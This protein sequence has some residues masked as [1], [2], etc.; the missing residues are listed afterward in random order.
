[1]SSRRKSPKFSFCLE[2]GCEE[3]G[4]NSPAKR[5]RLGSDRGFGK[6][7]NEKV[8]EAGDSSRLRKKARSDVV[9]QSLTSSG[10]VPVGEEN[11]RVPAQA[12]D[13]QFGSQ[14]SISIRESP[15]T[16][17]YLESNCKLSLG[18]GCV[19]VL[20]EVEVFKKIEDGK[21]FPG[22]AT[23]TRDRFWASTL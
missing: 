12:A 23:T 18:G 13:S 5:P 6:Y 8:V 22:H 10:D 3:G 15:T 19:E 2:V 1:M 4:L 11:F 20:K 7:G 17:T 14:P 9:W 21:G 16:N